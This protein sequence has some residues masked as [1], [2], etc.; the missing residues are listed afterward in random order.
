MQ[1]LVQVLIQSGMEPQ[2]FDDIIYAKKE[3]Y[4]AEK[5]IHVFYFPFGCISIWGAEDADE[6]SFMDELKNISVDITKDK[7]KDHIN[8]RYDFSK[9]KSFFD[10]ELDE[11]ILSDDTTFTKLTIS[12]ALAQSVKLSMLEEYVEN[13]M[14]STTPIRHE[15]SKTGRMSMS[16]TEISQK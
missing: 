7:F 8:Y 11:V 4:G 12:Y 9:D 2:Y 3:F 14:E 16:K 1:S 15:L 13:L 6:S 5:I 10:E